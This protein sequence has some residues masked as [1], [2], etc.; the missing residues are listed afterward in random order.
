MKSISTNMTISRFLTIGLFVLIIKAANAT[1]KNFFG[2]PTFFLGP[3]GQSLGGA[4]STQKITNDNSFLNPAAGAFSKEYAV[5][6]NFSTA[7][8]T[9]SA[10]VFDTKSTDYGAGM[11]YVHRDVASGD[12]KTPLM[13]GSAEQSFQSYGGSVFGKLHESFAVGVTAKYSTRTG[14]GFY[15]G[16]GV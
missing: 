13:A 16:K 8:R 5:N 10:T 1:P 14:T 15:N 12:T 4:G 2:D 3:V 9:L 6:A 7:A 11:F